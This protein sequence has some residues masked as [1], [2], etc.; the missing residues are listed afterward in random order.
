MLQHFDTMVFSVREVGMPKVAYC[1]CEGQKSRLP[2]K[3]HRTTKGDG[4]DA[5]HPAVYQEHQRNGAYSQ[6]TNIRGS[7]SPMLL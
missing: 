2:S 1:F 3:L 7:P 6:P 5:S 4:L